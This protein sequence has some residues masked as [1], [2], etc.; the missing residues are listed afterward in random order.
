[1]MILL[2]YQFIPTAMSS[3]FVDRN[4]LTG[5]NHKREHDAMSPGC[6]S[7]HL[8]AIQPLSPPQQLLLRRNI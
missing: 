2:L 7:S 8:Q 1:M 6:C 4:S 3:H 5:A